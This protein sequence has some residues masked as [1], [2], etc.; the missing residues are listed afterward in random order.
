M[1]RASGSAA[2]TGLATLITPM[3]VTDDGSMER[4]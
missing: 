1:S 4:E 3:S 2:G